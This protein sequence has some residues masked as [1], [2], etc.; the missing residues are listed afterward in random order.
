MG[1]VMAIVK[2]ENKA[3]GRADPRRDWRPR[4]KARSLTAPLA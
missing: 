3:A 4:I 2:E 1:K